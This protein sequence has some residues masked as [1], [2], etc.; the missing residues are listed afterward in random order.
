VHARAG[1]A[2]AFERGGRQGRGGESAGDEAGEQGGAEQKTGIRGHGGGERRK[3][4]P[5]ALSGMSV[6]SESA[7]WMNPGS[8]VVPGPS[9]K[10]GRGR[11]RSQ[12]EDFNL[13]PIVP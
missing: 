1:V 13:L 2:E 9:T 12:E 7:A 11:P 3:T 10:C 8:A 4:G 6:E 5:H